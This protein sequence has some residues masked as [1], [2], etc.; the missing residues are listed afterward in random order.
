MA[1]KNP[2]RI[3]EKVK[4]AKVSKEGGYLYFVDKEG[5]VSRVPAKWNEDPTFLDK[6]Q[7]EETIIDKK[8]ATLQQKTQLQQG[9]PNVV[10]SDQYCIA[11]FDR[12]ITKG[13]IRVRAV[14][15]YTLRTIPENILLQMM[16]TASIISSI[17]FETQSAEGSNLIL[18][19]SDTVEISVITRFSNDGLSLM[20]E[21]KQ[22]DPQIIKSV[23]N[24]IKQ[25]LIIGEIKDF[26]KV[27]LDVEQPKKKV[28]IVDSLPAEKNYL[29]Y[30]LRRNS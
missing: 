12:Q 20:W 14:E 7:E 23:A 6:I 11:L 21:M 3:P 28:N 22:G 29:I 1:E 16:T 8:I 9:T 4:K 26:S 18:N 17:L 30:D 19:E 5:D 25:K 27:N 24:A 13:H 2:N 15:K 10:Y